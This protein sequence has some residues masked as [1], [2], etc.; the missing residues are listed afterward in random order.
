MN[1]RLHP[2]TL[3][4]ILDRTAQAYRAGFLRF[5]G[6]ACAP[7]VVLLAFLAAAVGFFA[8]AYTE[9]SRGFSG[10][11]LGIVIV[12]GL[13]VLALVG[14]PVC[15][16]AM[17]LSWAA[18]TEA[19]A[20]VFLGGSFT[21]RSAFAGAWKQRWRLLWLMTM[22][23]LFVGVLP[24]SIGLGIAAASAAL[25]GRADK[26]GLGTLSVAL[27]VV[28]FVLVAAVVA[29]ALWLLLRLCLGFAVCVV[30]QVSAWQA[31][32]RSAK[33]AIGT[34]GRM[35]V[36]FLLGYAIET[37]LTIALFLVVAI[38][39]ALI[40]GLQGAKHADAVSTTLAFGFYA[41]SFLMQA[42][43]RPV[44]GIGLTL[45]YFDQRIRKEGFDIEWM[46]RNAGMAD[47]PAAG[48]ETAKQAG[49]SPWLALPEEPAGESRT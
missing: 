35:F 27:A 45:F 32:K 22:D 9:P 34:K 17:A 37:G 7:F 40:P 44:Y 12:V 28:M 26:A 25:G 1:E 10:N 13:G 4:E 41:L 15:T 43:V 46:M 48:G 18:I 21:L 33:L 29:G 23:A 20:A 5:V 31:L 42:L 36:L 6:I 39:V 11:P 19:A 3:G 14:L 38:I 16:G 49:A 47:L 30:E 2:L 24:G 8:W